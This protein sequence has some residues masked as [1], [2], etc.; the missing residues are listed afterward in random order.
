MN[1]KVE[2]ICAQILPLTLNGVY[3]G[4]ILSVVVAGIL[5]LL[6]RTNAATRHAIWLASLILIV[7]II[8]AHYWLDVGP[9]P[10]TAPSGSRAEPMERSLELTSA[11]PSTPALVW[12]DLNT[13]HPKWILG[14][15]ANDDTT[16]ATANTDADLMVPPSPEG[17]PCS[18]GNESPAQAPVS[19][20][21]K[22]LA[23]AGQAAVMVGQRLLKPVHWQVAPAAVSPV[24]AVVFVVWLVLSAWQLAF[25]VL[26]LRRLLRLREDTLPAETL[27]L[28]FFEKLK[29]DSNLC[30]PAQ[31]R[32]SKERRCPMVIGFFRPMVLLPR[33]LVTQASPKEIDHILR[34]EL[35]HV[36]R[37][38]DWA[39]LFQHLVQSVLFFHPSVW[40]INRKLS[41]ER[42]IACDDHV[43]QQGGRRQD[44]ALTLASVAGRLSHKTPMLAPGVSNSSSQLQ[45]RIHMILN[46]QRNA[47][48]R[49]AKGRTTIIIS[50]AALLAMLAASS[51]PRFVLS[52]APAPAARPVISVGPA[53]VTVQPEPAISVEETVAAVPSGELLIAQSEAP[54]VVAVG[55]D[56]GPK[57][58]PEPAPPGEPAEP[59]AAIAPEPPDAPAFAK[60]P[61]P[62]RGARAGRPAK[63][64]SQDADDDKDAD[65]S[66]EERLRR[67]EKMVR[68][69]M[70]QQGMKRSRG[71]FNVKDGYERNLNVDQQQLDQM[72]QAAERQAARAA[73]QAQRAAERVKRSNKELEARLE[74]ENQG[75]YRE[76]FQKQIEALRKA[77]ESL[78]QEMEKLNRQIEKLEKEQQRNER[79]QQRRGEADAENLQAQL[80]AVPPA[81]VK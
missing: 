22:F 62:P 49:L 16:S 6:V 28:S 77:R 3:Q 23:E 56:P 8:P 5:R 32:I 50:A 80:P 34:H 37:F 21:R 73:D 15:D 65:G 17:A 47:S 44:Y 48:A 38:D 1:A 31:L 58:K 33:D 20:F 46:T 26:K 75:N 78:N 2:E 54:A 36:A 7:L 59:A 71:D 53:G 51:G 68:A 10:E 19:G 79:D 13:D 41:L 9:G 40:W 4:I 35:A 24:I 27:L 55:V 67:V 64:R 57:F 45:Q 76:S 12:F 72:K 63:V 61:K 70:E 25:L 11:D 52:A 30:R 42:E 14:S 66:V 43:L 74:Q 60:P 81:P 18:P 29:T 69:L 39:N